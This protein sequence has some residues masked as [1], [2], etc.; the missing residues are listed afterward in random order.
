MNFEHETIGNE[1]PAPPLLIAGGIMHPNNTTLL[2]GDSGVGKGWVACWI[3]RELVREGYNP[4]ILDFENVKYEWMYRLYG[5]GI[6]PRDGVEWVRVDQ[7]LSMEAARELAWLL[8]ELGS[9]HVILDSASVARARVGNNDAGG[10]DATVRLFRAINALDLPTLVLA[11]RGKDG[12]KS[13]IGSMQFLAQARLVWRA[14]AEG[15]NTTLYMDMVNDRFKDEHPR[16][17][18]RVLLPDGYT[19]VVERE[20]ISLPRQHNPDSLQERCVDLLRSVNRSM[21]P[22][23][24]QRALP[25]DGEGYDSLTV[26]TATL[27]R[28]VKQGRLIKPKRGYYA[29]VLPQQFLT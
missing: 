7:S 21:T 5:M 27:T 3:V 23:E 19:D 22:S 13:P 18:T 17:F 8:F 16:P 9:T 20:D 26:I 25:K 15:L 6:R 24:V 4:V 1:P 14:E 2:Y 29:Y 28:L 12:S 10:Q 11:H